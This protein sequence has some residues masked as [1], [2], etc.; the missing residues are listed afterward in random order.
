MIEDKIDTEVRIYFFTE[1]Y[2]FIIIFV[3]YICVWRSSPIQIRKIIL[4]ELCN[5]GLNTVVNRG[6]FPQYIMWKINEGN[7]I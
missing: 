2:F 5:V 6:Y 3:N 4:S 7:R 1:F